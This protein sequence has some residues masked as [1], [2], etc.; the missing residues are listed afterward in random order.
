MTERALHRLRAG[1]NLRSLT[2]AV[3]ILAPFLALTLSGGD[4]SW[5][6][7]AVVAISMLIA[8]DR[9]GLAFL[10]AAV[11][12]GTILAG[13][14]ALSLALAQRIPALFVLECAGLAAGAVGLTHQ[15]ARLRS[16]GNFTFIPALYLAF[17]IAMDGPPDRIADRAGAVLPFLGLAMLPVLLL[18]LHDA[19]RRP[20]PWNGLGWRHWDK[21]LGPP[22]ACGESV[23]AVAIAVGL[24]ATLVEWRNLEYGQWVI[25]S[26][27]S[28]VTGDLATTPLKLRDRAF[29]ALVGVPAGIGLGAILPHAPV[30]YDLI[31]LST[32]L[33]LVAFTRYVA[34]FVTRCA[35]IACA[36]VVLDQSVLIATERIVNVLLGGMIGVSA[37]F[38]VHVAARKL[39]TLR[40][41]R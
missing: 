33:T 32:F 26:S 18:T 14:L 22:K 2:R 31:A 15:G 24:A 30:V 11:H 8:V 1:I 28:V 21:D 27:A 29:G 7:A 23:M 17:E 40:H 37:V 19:W 20:D 39:A 3:V 36:L 38:C 16:L 25:W 6:Q 5:L 41:R 4:R 13:F 9:T 12:G 34:G 10:G 35:G